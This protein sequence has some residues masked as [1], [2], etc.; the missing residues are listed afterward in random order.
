MAELTLVEVVVELVCVST[1]VEA[2]VLRWAR[3]ELKRTGKVYQMVLDHEDLDR[4]E[5]LAADWGDR[6]PYGLG[7]DRT[8]RQVL[9][10]EEEER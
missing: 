10:A 6:V 5:E 2:D 4:H 3:E 1:D 7:Q 9:R 8:V